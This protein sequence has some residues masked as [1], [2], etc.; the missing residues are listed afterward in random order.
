MVQQVVDA[1]TFVEGLKEGKV[2]EP[3]DVIADNAALRGKK[4]A[5]P[6]PL[7]GKEATDKKTPP[8]AATKND[9]A[10]DPDDVAGEDGLTPREKRE[11]TTKMQAAIGKRVRLQKEAEEFAAEQY[12]GRRLAEQELE[13]IERENRRL[14]AQIGGQPAEGTSAIATAPNRENFASEIEY[15]NAMVD[16]RVSQQLAKAQAEDTKRAQ[17]KYFE[18][19]RAQ[20][21]AR[22]Q[23][24]MELVPDY[25]ELAENA[26]SSDVMVPEH[27]GLYMQESPMLA[28]L[29]YYF[30]KNPSK[31][32]ELAKMP[33]GTSLVALGKIEA[34][35]KPFEKAQAPSKA[36]G[37]DS[38][39]PSDDGKKPSTET[40]TVVPSRP[41][42][43]APIT[44]LTDSSAG[45]S[46]KPLSEMTYAEAVNDWEKRTGR[47]L[48]LRKRH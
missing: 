36:N 6:K 29:G 9:A 27:I 41:R 33:A 10:S 40:G 24:A 5:D 34:I 8:A 43:G 35:L 25:R 3:A 15:I 20:G 42:A 2:I 39:L 31:M 38:S 12:N 14:Q 1:K 48:S 4:G 44:P 22:V 17:Q 7:N 19:V 32:E 47:S 18:E 23:K 37:K 11:L 45:Q 16:W 13:R 21:I 46:S 26:R 28:E 30:L